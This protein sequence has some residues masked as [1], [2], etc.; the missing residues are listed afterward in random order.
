MD[1]SENQLVGHLRDF[2]RKYYLNQ[3]I[4]GSIVLVLIV[5]SFLF[6][7]ILGEG[8]LGF[9]AGVRTTFMGILAATFLGVTGYMILWP[10][11]KLAQLTKGISEMEIAQMIRKHF[12]DIDDKLV[13][14]LQ[15]RGQGGKENELAMAAIR[16]R[17]EELA[18]IPFARAINLR[19]N[20]RYAR[21]LAIPLALFGIMWF[22]SPDLMTGG[23]FRLFNF[24]KDFPKPLPFNIHVTNNPKELV[25]GQS[26]ELKTL[27]DGKELPAE[28][29]LFLKKESE[30]EFISYPMKMVR[31]DEF[32]AAFTDVKE[33][34]TYYI[35]NELV[36]SDKF[37][38]EVLRRPSI[39]AFTALL[40]YPDYTGLSTDTLGANIGDVKVLKGTRVIWQLT[41]NG[42]VEEATYMGADTAAFHVEESGSFIH[43][44]TVLENESYYLSLR[45]ERNIFNLDTVRYHIE[46]LQ[47]RYPTVFVNTPGQD[48]QADY[49]L[50]MPLDFEISD[51]YGFS[52]LGLYYRFSGSADPTKIKQEY[53]GIPLDV[54]RLELLQHKGLEIDL[55]NLGMAEGDVI[56]YYVKVWDN[57]GISGAKASTS[58]V[59]GIK[60]ASL[61]E[62]YETVDNSQ[63][64]IDEEMKKVQE[65]L[66]KIME[67]Y[68]KFQDKLL[69]Q[70]GLSYDDQK[71]LKN[72]M[73]MQR[74]SQSQMQEMQKKFKEQ[75][76]FMKNN[77]M[78]SEETLQKYEKLNEF[79]EQ[80]NN[81][82][83]EEMMKKLQELMEKQDPAKL[84][85]QMEQ[86]K[87]NE[88]DMKKSLERTMELMKQLEAQ[89]K[90]EELMQ[91]L[92]DLKD[93][94]DM[95]NE[96]L[97]EQKGKNKEEMEK[98]AQKQE[99]LSK[100]MED[101]KKDLE[102]LEQKKSETST[103]DQDKMD[104]LKQDADGAKQDMDNAGEQMQNS[105]KKGSSQSQKDASQKMEKMMQSLQSMQS[106]SQ[107]KQ[108]EKNLEDLRELLENLLRLSFD[109]ED[110]RDE[111]RELR[112]NDPQLGLKA[113]TQKELLDDMYMIKDS[114][115]KLAQKVFQIEK[116]VLDESGKIVRSMT[117]AK[118]LM[119]TKDTR[120]ISEKQHQAMT[121]AN[122]LANM[123]TDV[124]QQMQA[125]MKANSKKP[126]NGSCNKPGG[127]NP[128]MKA[129]GEM[130]KDLNGQMK[131]MMG[132][133]MD[134]KK[135]AEMAAKQEALRQALK[136]AHEKVKG[137][138][139]KMLGDMGQVM[140][141]M[142]ETEEELKR[143]QLTAET[144]IRQQNILNRLLDAQKSVR[145]KEEYENRRESNSAKEKEA[146]SPDQLA[147]EEYKNRLRQEL[148]KTNQ[149]EYSSDFIILIEKYFKLLEQTNE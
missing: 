135:L 8:I 95:L 76:E 65:E 69:N 130:Q 115:D 149:L 64:N 58:P 102:D 109:Q 30:S 116:F 85:E 68:E 38:V 51:D 75:K 119:I 42:L 147:S 77:S 55:S 41:S 24:S 134:G 78:L 105:D 13:N 17:T 62:K 15:L 35:G 32:T 87:L 110:L 138:G 19:V 9:P 88:E 142:K 123:L 132:Q 80:M 12:P 125:Q 112:A 143:Q 7:S 99:E 133:G 36:N 29:Y 16:K 86:V 61:D 106:G 25:A 96:K 89:Q 79:M 63:K 4:R 31:A 128:S 114:L 28:L 146:H 131:E 90:A 101:I 92:Q 136:E 46:V 23:S 145:E 82:K 118:D 73:E 97:D 21:Y 10:A 144:L 26:Y 74:N 122:N 107:Q 18:P 98:L 47:D 91:K 139:G 39:K 127:S 108:D 20:M 120:R 121:S 48:F 60:Y 129:I 67:G 22:V 94:Q 100:Q 49:T 52:Q 57:D 103:P 70:K 104:E 141:D 81:P 83:M 33:N 54:K 137:E 50:K 44:K 71:E 6:V 140:E 5:S 148:L 1:R 45:S 37:N 84:K 43:S 111:M 124:M 14:L 93:K 56:E 3:I 53:T 2:R 72:L 126:G 34:F 11:S 66:K 59:F 40:D 27:I 117:E 113:N